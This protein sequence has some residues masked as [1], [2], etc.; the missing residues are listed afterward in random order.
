MIA[1]AAVVKPDL[2]CHVS[3]AT[4]SEVHRVYP[5]G[6]GSI[7]LHIGLLQATC[8]MESPY[9]MRCTGGTTVLTYEVGLVADL[10]SP[11]HETRGCG[12]ISMKSHKRKERPVGILVVPKC[13][14]K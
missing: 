11:L 7:P 14:N 12:D 8:G 2:D 1:A 3:I 10:C 9:T 4:G 6:A 13:N 5:S